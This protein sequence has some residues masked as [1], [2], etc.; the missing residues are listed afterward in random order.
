MHFAG[1]AENVLFFLTYVP[2]G[3]L[4]WGFYGYAT[5][6]G[7]TK[8]RLLD[9]DRPAPAVPP[10]VTILIPAKD[11][12]GRI[13]ACLASALAQDW[14]AFD[15]VAIDDRSDDA[16]GAI[17]DEMAA[18]DPR[19]SV[20]H[21]PRGTMPPAGWTGKNNALHV[22]SQQARGHWLLFVDSD[23]LLEPS[24]VRRATTVAQ[25][26]KYDLLSALPR[27]ETHTLWEGLLIPLHS[28]AAAT[29]YLIALVN[30][31]HYKKVSFANGQFLMMPRPSYDAIGGHTAVK[32]RF[33]EDTEIARLVK[34]SGMR[35]R[36]TWGGDLAAV[37]MYDSFGAILKGWSRI[38]Y[39]AKVGNPRH[40]VSAMAF[41]LVNCLTVYPALVYGTYRWTHPHGN[42]L[43]EAW[44][45]AA[46]I[47]FVTMTTI[48]SFMYKWSRNSPL[49]ALLFPVGGLVLFYT[50]CKALVLCFTKKL[51]WRGT[52]Y[53]HTM[54][55]M[56]AKQ[57]APA[58]PS[59]SAA[60]SAPA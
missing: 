11:E 37:R 36:V 53:S 32:D 59:G 17:M 2:A 50:L 15:V 22:G 25:Y 28:A 16:T 24:A 6:A 43:D 4:T 45:V 27:L 48:L 46:A 41:L 7:N 40:I 49:Y 35:C 18:A 58:E 30:N 51:E 26:K 60:G 14:P 8:M 10:H 44:L 23:V 21:V 55:A 42:M 57:V 52:S 12:A 13:R 19:L 20:V 47:H 29:M 56:A 3:P 9:K 31:D 39:A 38:F 54:N 34:E 1:I 5:S 33:C